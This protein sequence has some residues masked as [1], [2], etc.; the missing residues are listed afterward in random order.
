M[1]KYPFQIV[2]R[3]R[4]LNCVILLHCFYVLLVVDDMD[5]KGIEQPWTLFVDHLIQKLCVVNVVQ[6]KRGAKGKGSLCAGSCY[7]G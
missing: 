3:I 1:K 5:L 7:K 4:T 2:V 6:R